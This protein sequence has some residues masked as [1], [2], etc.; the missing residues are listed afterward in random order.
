[1]ERDT[2]GWV[3]GAPATEM[4]SLEAVLSMMEHGG[5]EFSQWRDVVLI[6]SVASRRALLQLG[7]A[8]QER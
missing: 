6:P 8:A 4:A 2:G 3:Q 5:D 7:A 1:V